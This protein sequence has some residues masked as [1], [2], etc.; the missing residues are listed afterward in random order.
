MYCSVSYDG[1]C[2]LCRKVQCIAAAWPRVAYTVNIWWALQEKWKSVQCIICVCIKVM[3][4]LGQNVKIAKAHS[5]MWS[6]VM[7]HRMQWF[8]ESLLARELPR[9]ETAFKCCSPCWW[10]WFRWQITNWHLNND[11]LRR[12]CERSKKLL[13]SWPWVSRQVPSAEV[14]QYLAAGNISQMQIAPNFIQI[15]G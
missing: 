15:L 2:H 1:R 9:V 12:Q 6:D 3:S 10:S 5:V 8:I 14:T 11:H 13:W 7:N 4:P